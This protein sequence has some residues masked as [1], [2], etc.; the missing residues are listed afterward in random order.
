MLVP[1][2]IAAEATFVRSTANLLIVSAM[3][4]AT[5]ELIRLTKGIYGH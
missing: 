5:P 1:E 2:A 4:G 3:S